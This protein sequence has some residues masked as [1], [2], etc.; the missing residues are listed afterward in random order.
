MPEETHAHL[1]R[2]NGRSDS[3]TSANGQTDAS[4]SA[5][6]RGDSAASML[7]PPVH[8]VEDVC[9]R[10]EHAERRLKEMAEACSAVLENLSEVD[11]KHSM[12]VAALN[13]RL[14]DW[15]DLEGKLLSELF[16]FRSK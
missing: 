11:R 13:E 1:T 4:T 5:N 3:L 7:T 15:F 9:D 12:T 6:A 8:R 14:G 16:G 2:A 10:L